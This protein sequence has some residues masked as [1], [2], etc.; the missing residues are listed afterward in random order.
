MADK[1]S[2]WNSAIGRVGEGSTVDDP[3]ED[4]VFARA[5]RRH[6]DLARDAVLQE[7]NWQFAKRV[8]AL[9]LVSDPPTTGWDY[10]YVPPGQCIAVHRVGMLRQ[11][12][13][14]PPY[15]T[16]DPG[17]LNANR[18]EIENT[19]W[20]GFGI[21]NSSGDETAVIGSNVETAY[22]EYTRQIT[23]EQQFPPLFADALAW[24]LAVD[25]AMAAP[26]SESM[27]QTA[28]NGYNVVMDKA[29]ADSARKR[30]DSRPDSELIRARA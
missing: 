16:L 1:L 11:S 14:I 20:E 27:R 2:I 26:R 4:T 21:T 19:P 23:D 6:Y 5:C 24:R 15:A 17:W 13:Y 29:R 7:F 3:D 25:L 12:L 30:L 28:W 9:A 8:A 10:L 22:A 18:P